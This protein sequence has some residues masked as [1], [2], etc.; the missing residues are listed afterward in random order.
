MEPIPDRKWQDMIGGFDSDGNPVPMTFEL[1]QDL[2]RY[3]EGLVSPATPSGVSNILATSRSLF[4]FSWFRY[5]FMV[6]GCLTA[7]QALEAA[8]RQVLYPGASDNTRFKKL[9][10]KA[11]VDG[12]IDEAT[13]DLI[14]SGAELRN[15]LSH[16]LDQVIVSLDMAG[17]VMQTTHQVISHLAA[18]GASN[19][20]HFP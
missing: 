17:S 5:E 15:A 6:V 3:W 16:P 11:E 1:L 12:I 9:V 18:I 13:T 14:V 2:A 19:S 20:S 7:F 10:K 4:V 8:F